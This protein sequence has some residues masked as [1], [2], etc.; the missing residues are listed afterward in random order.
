MSISHSAKLATSTL[1]LVW[2][3]TLRACGV[4]GGI[5]EGGL[6]LVDH[7][8]NMFLRYACLP[9][10]GDAARGRQQDPGEDASTLSQ[11]DSESEMA[12]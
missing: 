3:S 8:S 2:D 1:I 4:A 7:H 11:R 9:C 12:K 10:F 6:G 5:Q